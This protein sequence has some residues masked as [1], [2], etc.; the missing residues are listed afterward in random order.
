MAHWY[1]IGPNFE[2]RIRQTPLTMAPLSNY[3]VQEQRDLAAGGP[4]V[5]AVTGVSDHQAGQAMVVETRS[6]VTEAASERDI[7]SVRLVEAYWAPQGQ[8]IGIP[9][10]PDIAGAPEL[11]FTPDLSGCS[12]V[13]E[14][15]GD[16]TLR[17]SHVQG[18]HHN[19]EF[20]SLHIEPRDITAILSHENYSNGRNDQAAAFLKF[21]RGSG[22]WNIHWQERQ[23]TIH[24]RGAQVRAAMGPMECAGYYCKPAGQPDQTAIAVR[25]ALASDRAEHRD[26]RFRFTRSQSPEEHREL[27]SMD[28][29]ISTDSRPPWQRSRAPNP[30]DSFFS[31]FQRRDSSDSERSR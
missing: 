24:V 15:K 28:A 11:V 17:V 1:D 9:A 2:D 14:K 20:A 5:F 19:E 31:R 21:D 4:M 6:Q 18:G 12:V 30:R 26:S 13:V 27:P 22:E 25:E 3:G 23:G 29:A 8:S 10:R 7:S 16:R